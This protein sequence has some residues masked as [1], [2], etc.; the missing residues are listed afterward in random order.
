MEFC[1]D[2]TEKATV[3]EIL[4][5]FAVIG[6]FAFGFWLRGREVA[7]QEVK[8][9]PIAPITQETT[10]Q[11]IEEE[12]ERPEI[13]VELS[14]PDIYKRRQAIFEQEQKRQRQMLTG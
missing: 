5:P 11:P 3:I 6:A 12:R 14:P 8:V 4:F 2:G 13:T 10:P 9:A 7:V 1:I